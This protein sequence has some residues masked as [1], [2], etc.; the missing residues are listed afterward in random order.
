MNDDITQSNLFE[1]LKQ[2]RVDF[3][4]SKNLFF[5]ASTRVHKVEKRNH[6]IK[7]ILEISSILISVITLSSVAVYFSQRYQNES[8]VIIGLLS[9]IEIAISV[10]LLTMNGDKLFEEY[11]KTADGYL[12]LY[13]KAKIFEAKV[14]DKIMGMVELSEKVEELTYLQSKLSNSKLKTTYEDFVIAKDHISKGSNSYSQSDFE[15]T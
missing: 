1:R 6:G 15:N 9:I 8:I 5:A 14:E 7:N 10:S 2:L 11:T 13:K 4:Y 12:D 3:A